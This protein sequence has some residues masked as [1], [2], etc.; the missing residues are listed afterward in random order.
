MNLITII[1]PVFND[2]KHLEETINSVLNQTYKNWEWII[3]DD[4]STDNSVKI[5]KKFQSK[6]KRIHLIRNSKNSGAAFSRNVALTAARGSYI[7]YL[8]ADDLWDVNKLK[9][10]LSFMMN[11]NIDFS[12]CSY[13]VIDENSVSLKKNVIMLNQVDYRTFL[14]NN[15]LQTV[16]IMIHISVIGKEL[17]QMPDLRRRQD[18]ATWLKILKAGYSCYGLRNVLSS[19]RRTKN[20]LS[21]NKVKSVKGVW[22]LY[23]H[24]EQLSLIFSLYCFSRYAFLAVWKRIYFKWR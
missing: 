8:D 5:I 11:N 1:T 12:C 2:E 23:R 18:A 6:T 10:Q 15:L 16:G 20:S 22:Y 17:C 19:Y 13:R 21:S 14:T 7:A 24:V 4:C 9:I 3:V